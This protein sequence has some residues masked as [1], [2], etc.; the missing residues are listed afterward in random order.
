[1]DHLRQLVEDMVI[2]ALGELAG[3]VAAFLVI[4]QSVQEQLV[5]EITERLVRR[6]HSQVKTRMQAEVVVAR[7]RLVQ[8]QHL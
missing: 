5:R 1:L 8:P 3:R 6:D 2:K 7:G 4:T